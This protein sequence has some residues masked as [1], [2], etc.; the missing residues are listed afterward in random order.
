MHDVFTFRARLGAPPAAVYRALTDGAA[1]ETWLAERAEVSLSEGRLAFWGR[2][3]PQGDPDRQRLLATEPDR[4]LRFAWEL[5]GE[6]TTAEIRVETD[7][8]EGT[9]LTLTQTGAPA[10]EELMASAGRKDGLH[11]IHTFWPLAIANLANH[12][13]GRGLVPMCDFGDASRGEARAGLFVGTRPSGSG[14]P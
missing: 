8:A 7:G 3:T 9:L 11:S 13:E 1:L 10:L 12:M 6:E 2:H 5:D 4:L 14:P